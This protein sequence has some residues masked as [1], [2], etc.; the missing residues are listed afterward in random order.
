MTLE[1][2]SHTPVRLLGDGRRKR[3]PAGS[4]IKTEL[5]LVDVSQLFPTLPAGSTG[6]VEIG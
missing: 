2:Q 6:G 1:F 4:L 5:D 3:Q